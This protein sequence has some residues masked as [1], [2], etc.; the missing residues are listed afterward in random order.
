LVMSML[1]SI[2]YIELKV[3]QKLLINFQNIYKENL[4]KINLILLKKLILNSYFYL[5]G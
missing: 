5:G 3:Y 4:K 1:T 2:L